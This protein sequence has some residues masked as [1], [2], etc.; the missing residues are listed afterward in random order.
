[1]SSEVTNVI[2]LYFTFALN[3]V[4]TFHD[5]SM[6]LN[7]LHLLKVVL[8]FILDPALSVLKYLM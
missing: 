2:A 3:I 6:I 5:F 8:Y 4:T 1:M 7:Y